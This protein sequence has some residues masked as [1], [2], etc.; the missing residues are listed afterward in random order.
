M[1]HQDH[2][3]FH[4]NSSCLI[5]LQWR[6]CGHIS[7]ICDAYFESNHH[8]N[9]WTDSISCFGETNRNPLF[10]IVSWTWYLFLSSHILWLNQ[11]SDFFN[12]FNGHVFWRELNPLNSTNH[13]EP[14]FLGYVYHLAMSL[15]SVFATNSINI[16]AGINGLEVGQS[17]VIGLSVLAHHFI[18]LIY[19]AETTNHTISIISIYLMLPFVTTSLALFYYNK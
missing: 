6:H 13:L 14:N 18:Q 1:E 8:R 17:I 15:I 16:Y 11:L 2:F 7:Q 10:W 3:K 12:Q 4:C 9:D 5:S 19:F